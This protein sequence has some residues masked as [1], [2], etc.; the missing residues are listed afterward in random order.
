MT[1][2]IQWMREEWN[3]TGDS[4]KILGTSSTP[5]LSRIQKDLCI[6]KTWELGVSYYDSN[7]AGE[8]KLQKELTPCIFKAKISYTYFRK[9]ADY[10]AQILSH[11]IFIYNT[12][13]T[14]FVNLFLS[15]NSSSLFFEFFFLVTGKRKF[16]S[17]LKIGYSEILSL[18]FDKSFF[19]TGIIVIKFKFRGLLCFFQK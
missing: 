8:T 3:R 1:A 11:L 2:I 7:M 5:S 15:V 10:Y 9:Y 13:L 18:L 12:Y 4:D 6:R 16:P 14:C 17:A 19:T